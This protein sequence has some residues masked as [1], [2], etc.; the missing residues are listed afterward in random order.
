M[1]SATASGASYSAGT[2][3]R[4]LLGETIGQCLDRVAAAH[5]ANEALVDVATGRRWTYAQLHRDV[6]AI[7]LGL[8][9]LGID[10]GD[11]VGIWAPNSA[12]WTLRP[13]RDGPGRRDPRDD[14]PGI[15]PPRAGVRAQPVRR[16]HAR[17]RCV[18]QGQ[19]LRRHD[20][21]GQA[22][23]V[24]CWTTSSCSAAR[25]GTR[26]PARTATERR[27]PG[28]R[29]CSPPMTRST[30]STRPGR[31]AIPRARRSRTTT[32]STTPTRSP[33]S[34]GTPP[35]DR[36][37]VPLPLYHTFGMV[38]GNLGSLTHGAC[39]VYPAPSFDARS[40][41]AAV[42]QRALHVA[43][44]GADDVHRRARGAGP[45]GIR[46]EQPAHRAHGRLARARWR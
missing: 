44:R 24:R 30:S 6:E 34:A 39:V 45:H 32:S 9:E 35:H 37:C 42:A 46:P 3:D 19:R 4:P 36:V 31:P 11:R 40:T 5:P 21:G 29:R 38:I 33:R 23:V 8:L 18:V 10:K 1:I 2:G 27:W 17:R 25:A 13:V 43:L 15:P 41:L 28:G 22:D 12:E 7:A 26:W 16:P 20:R 14:Q